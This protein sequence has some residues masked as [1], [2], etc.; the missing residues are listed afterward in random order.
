MPNFDFTFFSNQHLSI[1]VR[2]KK[3]EEALKLVHGI[4][5]KIKPIVKMVFNNG[6]VLYFD[7]AIVEK[8]INKIITYDELIGQLKCTDVIINKNTFTTNKG[9]EMDEGALWKRIGNKCILIDDDHYVECEY[10]ES[11]FESVEFQI[12]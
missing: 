4:S 8:F 11:I 7:D 5:V 12:N 6:D 9:I 2:N 1:R 10:L 3:F